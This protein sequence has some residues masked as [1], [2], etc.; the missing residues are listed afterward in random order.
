M[1]QV[2]ELL[3]QDLAASAENEE[4]G[5]SGDG[6]GSVAY[7]KKVRRKKGKQQSKVSKA[8]E[9]CTTYELTHMRIFFR[10]K[11]IG[12]SLNTDSTYE[13]GT[14]MQVIS[15]ALDT[16]SLIILPLN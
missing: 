4:G 6:T 16:E 1:E 14:W 3:D 12:S 13:S 7:P 8:E 9:V 2:E 11:N 5:A 10:D 15:K